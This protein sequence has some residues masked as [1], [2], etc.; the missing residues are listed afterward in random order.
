MTAHTTNVTGRRVRRETETMV[1]G[2]WCVKKKEGRI[3][4]VDFV[5]ENEAKE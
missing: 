3:G 1:C 2:V 4:H 5:E